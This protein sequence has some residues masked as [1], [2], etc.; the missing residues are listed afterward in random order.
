MTQSPWPEKAGSDS[1]DGLL[2]AGLASLV[3]GAGLFMLLNSSMGA[4][5]LSRLDGVFAL[6]T[7]QLMWYITRAS[8]LMAYVLL[9]LSTAW[10]LAV[11]S[12]IFDRLLH[13]T[14]TYDYHQVLSLLSVGFLLLH[15]GVLLF[16]R[17]MPYSVSQLL[18]PF[19]SPY[20]PLWVGVGVIAFYLIVL[21]TVT[22]YF[23]GRIGM[24]AFRVIHMLSLLGYLGGLA[25]SVF[26]GTDSVLPATQLFYI[27]TFLVTVF[28]LAYWVLIALQRRLA[29]ILAPA[30]APVRHR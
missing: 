29:T 30:R 3:G 5:L 27:G 8:G 4:G 14:F 15:M 2:W 11:S 19:I 28:L 18:V 24:R 23:R 1:L 7:V 17:Y 12:K 16:D 10:G 6:S 26:A 21:V 22:F 20:R 13:R 9:W 25:H